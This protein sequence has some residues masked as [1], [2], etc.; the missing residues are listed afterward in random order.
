MNRLARVREKSG[1]PTLK[2]LVIE[3]ECLTPDNLSAL[4]RGLAN[5]REQGSL[6][7]VLVAHYHSVLDS[8]KLFGFEEHILEDVASPVLTPSKGSFHD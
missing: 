6:D 8:E 5:I 3:A 2:A 4:L 7:N 1:L